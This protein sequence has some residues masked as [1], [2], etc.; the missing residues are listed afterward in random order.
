MNDSE[1]ASFKLELLKIAAQI[2]YDQADVFN[3]YRKLIDL[4]DFKF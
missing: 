2:G 4:L 1:I 3:V